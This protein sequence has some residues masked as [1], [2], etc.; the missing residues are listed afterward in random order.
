M[1][2]DERGG[3]TGFL[4]VEIKERGEKEEAKRIKEK[5][6]SGDDAVI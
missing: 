3:E 6:H 5:K 4:M 1:Q 2:G